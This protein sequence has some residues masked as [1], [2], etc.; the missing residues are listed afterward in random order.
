LLLVNALQ[1]VRDYK[2]PVLGDLADQV[3]K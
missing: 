3:F 2:L 1:E